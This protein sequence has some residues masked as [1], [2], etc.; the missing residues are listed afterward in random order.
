MYIDGKIYLV[1]GGKIT[2]YEPARPSTAGR[3]T[4]RGDKLL[5]PTAPF[6]T[7]L[8][9]DNPAQDQGNFYAYDGLEPA[10][11]RVQEDRRHRR[12]PVHGPGEHAVVHGPQAACSSPTGASGA[13]PTLYWTESGNLMSA[14]LTPAGSTRRRRD[15]SGLRARPASAESGLGGS[16]R[17]R[18][19]RPRRPRP[20]EQA[21][22]PTARRR[23][24]EWDNPPM[25]ESLAE[26]VVESVRVH[27]LSSQH[28]VLLKETERER[29]LRSGSGR[30]RPTPSPRGFRA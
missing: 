24:A 4:R 8:A 28:V 14:S 17:L 6:Y 29:Y 25:A 26:V 2:Q 16:P 5:R 13:N 18:S 19:A 7:R 9:A 11:R 27:M 22:S 12:R 30:G 3:P 23:G 1:D 20:G 10:H 21:L 15:P